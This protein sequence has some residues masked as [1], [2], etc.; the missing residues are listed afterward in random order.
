[1]CQ[2]S[3]GRALP[4]YLLELFS[5]SLEEKERGDFVSRKA[6][7]KQQMEQGRV[8]VLRLLTTGFEE[9]ADKQKLLEYFD[10]VKFKADL[11]AKFQV[12]ACC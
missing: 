8:E 10:P 7:M 5:L 4:L 6:S 9:T 3:V 11:N 2:D 1:M 12:S